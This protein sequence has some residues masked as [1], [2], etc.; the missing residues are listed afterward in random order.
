MKNDHAYQFQFVISIPQFLDA[1]F[2]FSASLTHI[3]QQ[4]F[5]RKVATLC[6]KYEIKILMI[7]WIS[8]LILYSQLIVKFLTSEVRTNFFYALNLQHHRTKTVKYY[9]VK[10][11]LT[12]SVFV[13]VPRV[14]VWDS[15]RNLKCSITFCSKIL[16]Y[17]ND[18]SFNTTVLE[19]NWNRYELKLIV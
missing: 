4:F 17:K 6:P 5:D 3:E 14:S 16:L 18:N 19:S 15:R 8:L 1:N 12:M 10:Q 9:D 2:Q 7:S 13:F 11:Y